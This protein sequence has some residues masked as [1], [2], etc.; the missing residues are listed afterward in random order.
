MKYI[1]FGYS[2]DVVTT[3]GQTFAANVN[4]AAGSVQN[5]NPYGGSFF[6]SP[7]QMA[8]ADEGAGKVIT[9]IPSPYARMHLTAN[10]F[11]EYVCGDKIVTANEIIKRKLSPDYKR[12]LSHCLDMFEMLFHLSAVDLESRGIKVYSLPLAKPANVA[13]LGSA[14]LTSYVSTLDL[15]RK[16]Y[17]DYFRQHCPNYHFD[18]SSLYVFEADNKI[19]GATSPFTG[20]FTTSDCDLAGKEIVITNPDNGE[21]HKLLTSDPK[22]WKG[23]K[24]RSAEFRK[25]LYLLLKDN[26]TGLG[27]AFPHLFKAVSFYIDKYDKQTSAYA[28]LNLYNEY[29]QFRSCFEMNQK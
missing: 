27:K 29:P 6:D 28:A 26:P 8:T 1:K 10:A 17:V 21:K 25:F 20:F 19:F 14:N 12:A 9:S 3:S 7:I 13:S 24:E 16:K 11:H 5:P 22:D 15:F 18:F 4:K 2:C 23:L